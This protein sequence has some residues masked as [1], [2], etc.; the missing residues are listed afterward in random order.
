LYLKY[1]GSKKGQIRHQVS[2]NENGR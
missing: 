2:H 1:P